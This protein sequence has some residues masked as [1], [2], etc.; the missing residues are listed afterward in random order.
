MNNYQAPRDLLDQQV[1]L[2]TGA[3]QGLGRAAAL[4]F[5]AH[6]ARVIL[7]GRKV[8]KLEQVYDEIVEQDLPEPVIFPLDLGEARDAD[9]EAMANAIRQQLGRLDGILHSATALTPLTPLANQ[10]LEQWQML[11]R[12]NLIAPF[13]LTRAC[14]PL[15][16]HAAH[17]SIVITSETHGHTPAA[18][19]GGFAISKAALETL[20]KIWAQE[21]EM[22]PNVRINALVPGAVASPQR[23]ASHPGELKSELRSPEALMPWYLYLI[24]RD[25]APASG[26]IFCV[27]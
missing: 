3:G 4:A 14:L 7:H 20:V 27:E 11:M 5:A 9:F 1:I 24:G 26:E 2:V 22:H 18:Y 13:A 21:L 12:V 10:T 15:L 17:A 19:W 25:S 8:P 6:G 16:K 23:A